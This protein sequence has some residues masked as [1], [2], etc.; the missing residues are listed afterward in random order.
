VRI[1]IPAS[2]IARLKGLT[3]APGMPVEAFIHTSPCTVMAYLI[4]P[5]HDQISRPFREK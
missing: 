1:A 2:E 4:K 5:L 3:I